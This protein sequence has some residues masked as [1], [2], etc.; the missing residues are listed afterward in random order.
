MGPASLITWR[1]VGGVA[2]ENAPRTVKIPA[3][4]KT[5]VRKLMR[6]FILSF[7]SNHLPI[8]PRECSTQFSPRQAP[9]AWVSAC[10]SCGLHP[11][12]RIRVFGQFYGYRVNQPL[13]RR[14]LFPVTFILVIIDECLS[15]LAM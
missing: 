12:F 15:L 5:T 6:R 9:A 11:Q 10:A 13:G 7:P 8:S 14:Q 1:V 4:T 3:T 2:F